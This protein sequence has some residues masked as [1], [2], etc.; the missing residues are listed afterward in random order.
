MLSFFRKKQ[1]FYLDEVFV[2]LQI[3]LFGNTYLAV[4]VIVP[5]IFL[6]HYFALSTENRTQNF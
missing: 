2:Y 3:K 4:I 5:L 1:E 6:V